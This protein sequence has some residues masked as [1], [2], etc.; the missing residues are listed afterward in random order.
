MRV[1]AV[2][3]VTGSRC[4]AERQGTELMCQLCS[5]ALG[6]G[7]VL[8]VF[9]RDTVPQEVAQFVDGLG[10]PVGVAV[11][12]HC[13]DLA[14]VRAGTAAVEQFLDAGLERE[15]FVAGLVVGQAVGLGQLQEALDAREDLVLH[16]RELYVLQAGQGSTV[17]VEPLLQVATQRVLL[18]E[19]AHDRRLAFLGES[20]EEV[21]QGFVLRGGVA[22]GRDVRVGHN[23]S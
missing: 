21:A 4:R 1:A 6:R 8:V 10:E 16:Q 11:D 2:G 15:L 23:V 22:G 20:R 3:G 7:V 12:E 9:S 13:D 14:G 5:S 18:V 19:Q 17:G